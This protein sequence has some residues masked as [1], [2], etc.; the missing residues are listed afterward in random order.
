MNKANA[1]FSS[2][3]GGSRNT[4]NGRYSLALGAYAVSAAEQSA[5]LSFGNSIDCAPSGANSM[6]ICA[7]S[8]TINDNEVLDLF[9]RRRE[10]EDAATSTQKANDVLQKSNNALQK[11]VAERAEQILSMT[12]QLE[13]FANL[14]LK[15]SVLKEKVAHLKTL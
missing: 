3:A 15:H 12:K 6:A 4:V 11:E 14:Q 1:K 8:L 9:S 2:I 7:D 13:S 10:L 5:I